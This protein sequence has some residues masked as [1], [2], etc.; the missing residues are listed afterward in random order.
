[1]LSQQNKQTDIIIDFPFSFSSSFFWLCC[2]KS[3]AGFLI[4]G[5]FWIWQTQNKWKPNLTGYKSVSGNKQNCNYIWMLLITVTLYTQW[6]WKILK[7]LCSHF[8]HSCHLV[9]KHVATSNISYQ[10]PTSP[11][12]QRLQLHALLCL[13]GSLFPPLLNIY[14]F[15]PWCQD[16]RRASSSQKAQQHPTN[17]H[18]ITGLTLL[19]QLKIKWFDYQIITQLQQLP[20]SIDLMVWYCASLQVSLN[21]WREREREEKKKKSEK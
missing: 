2:L 11:H 1:M 4:T 16:A 8:T 20:W 13:T 18:D 6:I 9:W 15:P 19:Y 3:S 21:I 14:V 7:Y 12:C 10:H 5:F 17:T